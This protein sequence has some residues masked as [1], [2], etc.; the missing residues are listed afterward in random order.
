MRYRIR[1]VLSAATVAVLS[2]AGLALAG[3]AHAVSPDVVISEVYGGGGNGGA[4]LKQDFIEL[5]N[6]GAAEVD[7]TGWSVQYA[8]STGSSWQV[9]ALTGM[10]PA[11]RSYLVGEGFGSGGT[12]DLPPPDATGSIAMSGASGKVALVTDS[13]AL[14]CGATQG[15][16]SAVASVRDLVGY[17]AAPSDSETAPTG[18]NLTST[19][20]AAR[21]G[22]GTDTD[23]NSA[24]FATAAPTPVNCGEDC[25]APPP[26]GIE[27]L[28]IHDVQGAA[29]TSPYVD[30]F[31]VDVPGIV[32]AV[33]SNRFWMQDPEPD[34]DPGTSEGI[35]VF[36]GSAPTVAVGDSV[37]V[38]GTVDEFGFSGQLTTTEL[39]DPTVT[40]VGTAVQE[41][42]PTVI[43][44]GGRRPPT[45]VI[46]DDQLTRF[47]PQTDG[48]DFYESLEGMLVQVDDAQVVGPTS[49]FGELPV[50]TA[51]AGIRTS[52][53]GVIIRPNDL[54][55]E[56]IILDDALIPAGTMPAADVGDVLAGSTVG[57]EDYSFGNFK[58]LVTAA[59]TVNS[60]SLQREVTAPRTAQ[61]LAVATMNVENL[62]A[63]DDQAK[64]DRLA[65]IVADNL[66]S[67]DILAVEEIQDNDGPTNSTVVDA[68]ATYE[69][70]IAAIAAAGGPTYAYRQIDPADD[71]DGGQPGG[72]IRV[73][74]LFRTDTGLRFVDRP[75]GDATTPVQVTTLFGRAALS[76]SPGRIA[77]QDP[78]WDSSRK[79]LAGWFLYRGQSLFVVANHFNSK[80]GDDALFGS[81]QPPVR[82]SEDQRHR[83]ADLVRDFA[84]RLLAADPNANVVVLGDLND[85]QFS[86]TMRI[87]ES[88]GS[89]SNLI[90]TLPI[91][92][93]YTYVFDGNSQALDHT[94]LSPSLLRPKFGRPGFA[95]DVVHVNAE[96]ADQ[97]SDHDP[98]VV[99]LTTGR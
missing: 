25:A 96:F 35:V 66:R 68:S 42:A 44:P 71:Q 61:Q 13:T 34:A 27:G 46:D 64:F 9:T 77:P 57:V 14:T 49:G 60:G 15:S 97:A 73:G 33:A 82:S 74:F 84:D 37:T 80:G 78:A 51:G 7:I 1:A 12:V 59:P 29:H 4:D 54:N 94:L 93:Q 50:V 36:T 69:R 99:R 89:L 67:P 91:A 85:F 23:D 18:T 55:P 11:G 58:L 92:E 3:P 65:A 20:S 70:F 90:S 95:Y 88:T 40:L 63:T 72:N 47:D 21:D 16:C 17:G 32:T 76:I 56:R 24:D 83:Q 41:I 53:G 45:V 19:T 22:I 62:A 75:G 5:F 31:V 86:E 30:A 6:A 28:F 43:G 87:L 2:A 81:R 48:I 26:I 39:T 52:R 79:P 38:S 8:S 10:I 98:Q